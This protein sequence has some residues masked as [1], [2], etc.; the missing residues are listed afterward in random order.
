MVFARARARASTVCVQMRTS[1]Y[2]RASRVCCPRHQKGIRRTFR[3]SDWRAGVRARARVRARMPGGGGDAKKPGDAS[4]R[5]GE[6]PLFCLTG[7]RLRNR[8]VRSSRRKPGRARPGARDRRVC[9]WR[10]SVWSC[11]GSVGASPRM[12]RDRVAHA[13]RA[14]RA[15]SPPRPA[16]AR[17]PVKN[18]GKPRIMRPA[19]PYPYPHQ[20]PRVSSL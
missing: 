13:A 16:S 19:E 4:V 12:H 11:H 2:A 10:V 17:W 1:E 18:R 8:I 14:A 20:V 9:V 5:P 3:N 7:A 15:R 6:S